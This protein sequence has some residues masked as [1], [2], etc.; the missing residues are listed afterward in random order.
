MLI[1]REN[2]TKKEKHIVKTPPPPKK[3]K[4]KKKQRKKL[5]L[6][7]G[8]PLSNWQVNS[9][10]STLHTKHNLGLSDPAPLP[11]LHQFCFR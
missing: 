1:C 9:G 7:V 2:V 3:K 4:K 6:K 10:Q 11:P 8:C 5:A